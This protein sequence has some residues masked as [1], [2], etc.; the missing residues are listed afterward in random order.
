MK[1]LLMVLV[2]GACVVAASAQG[3][4]TC[5]A[6]QK[7]AA[8]VAAKSGD[9]EYVPGLQQGV[10]RNGR[11]NVNFSATCAEA[12]SFSHTLGTILADVNQTRTSCQIRNELTG[13]LE[14]WPSWAAI[15]YEGEMYFEGGQEYNFFGC[16]DDLAAC[17]LDGKCFW[18]VGLQQINNLGVQ[19]YSKKFEE[20]GWHPIRVWLMDIGWDRG[21]VAR[22]VGFQ[23]MGIGW[24]TNGCKVVNATTCLQWSRLLDDGSGRLLRSMVL[25]QKGARQDENGPTGTKEGDVRTFGVQDGLPFE[26]EM[27]WVD[28]CR[29]VDGFWVGKNR[30]T[31]RQWKCIMGYDPVDKNMQGE[32]TPIGQTCMGRGGDLLFLWGLNARYSGAGRFD[33]LSDAQWQL[34]AKYA[35]IALP[36]ESASF[37]LAFRPTDRR[38]SERE[39]QRQVKGV[40][41]AAFAVK[42]ANGEARRYSLAKGLDLDVIRVEGCGETFYL[43]RYEVTVEQYEKVMTSNPSIWSGAANLPVGSV[44]WTNATVFCEKLNA[45]VPVEGMAWTLPTSKQWGFVA[46]GGLKRRANTFFGGNNWQEVGWWGGDEFGHN[47]VRPVGL[48][49]PNELGFHDLFGNCWEWCSDGDGRKDF[50][51]LGGPGVGYAGGRRL[52]ESFYSGRMKDA[53]KDWG[54]RVALVKSSELLKKAQEEKAVAANNRLRRPGG[55]LG[56]SLRARRLQRQQAAQADAAKQQTEE[57]AKDAERQAQAAAEKAQREAERAEQRR[58]LAAINEE[59]KKVREQKAAAAKSE[60]TASCIT[61]KPTSG[62]GVVAEKLGQCDFLLNRDFK[63][64]AKFYL[65]LFSASWC[66]PCRREMPRIAKTYAEALK[67]DP[68]IELIHFSRDQDEEKAM[69]WAKEHD[70]KFPVVKPRGGNPLDLHSRGIPHLFIVKADGTVLEEGHPMRIFNEEKFQELKGLKL[71]CD[72][73]TQVDK[74]GDRA[75]GCTEKIDGYTWSYRVNDG[76]ATIMKLERCHESCAVSPTPKG[77]V[78]V[79]A[80]LGGAK[81]TGIGGSAFVFCHEMTSVTLPDTVKEIGSSA[82]LGCSGLTTMTIPEGVTNIGRQAFAGCEKLKSIMIPASVTSIGGG[83]FEWCRKLSGIKLAEGNQRFAIVDG[84]LYTK[85]LSELIMCPN[86]LT[87]VKIPSDVRNIGVSSFEGCEGLDSVTIPEGVT[88]IGWAAFRFCRKFKSVTIPASMVSIGEGS[89]TSCGALKEILAEPGNRNFTSV[90]GVLYTKDRSELVMCPNALTSAVILPEVKTVRPYAFSGCAGMTSITIPNGVTNIRHGAFSDCSG[91]KSVVVPSSVAKLG[92]Q[93]F[94]RCAELENVTFLGER[95]DSIKND[96]GGCAKL[97]AIH[98]P[99][100]A[101][102][103]AGMK[104]WQG[105]PL[106]FDAEAK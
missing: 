34:A 81:V 13:T 67:D 39:E 99:A 73:K 98:V 16:V 53:A 40:S 85:D 77:Y 105:I 49:K 17:E 62:K 80:T 47:Y 97:T 70:V 75:N 68:D 28:G 54:L 69:A 46:H 6:L 37:R 92:Q 48:K 52:V 65:C 56:G 94:S 88:N 50:R 43:G 89:F 1:K 71:A 83:V 79:P 64:N 63:K 11:Y 96:F 95:P 61:N 12:D 10:F 22:R 20:S 33:R 104:E 18:C 41:D 101:K 90:D 82:F 106:V 55:L 8:V 2:L 51:Y 27:V 29:D 66:G 38:N 78:T 84:V 7:G 72:M 23:G 42:L 35:S 91:L 44:D 9:G 102:S 57:A 93:A 86:T 45:L 15:L 4:E 31:H 19:V 32:D 3:Q 103:W 74:C 58:Q 36:T 5:S 87:S 59:L 60:C 100:N 26:V 76:D 25:P 24:N 30:V 21:A 14:K